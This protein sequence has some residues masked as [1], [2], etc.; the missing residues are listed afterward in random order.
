MQANINTL[1]EMLDSA[2]H[3]VETERR[4]KNQPQVISL[5]EITWLDPAEMRNVT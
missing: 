2:L 4:H 1:I 3:T 5:Q